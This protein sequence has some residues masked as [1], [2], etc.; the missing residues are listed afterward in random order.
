M[1]LVLEYQTD[2]KEELRILLP[3]HI[4]KMMEFESQPEPLKN[5]Q[6]ISFVPDKKV[7]KNFEDLQLYI[8][9]SKL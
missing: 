6:K 9:P 8:K 2:K 1:I 3:T 5:P 4:F 7:I